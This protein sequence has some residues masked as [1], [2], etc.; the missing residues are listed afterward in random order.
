M[1]IINCDQDNI[2]LLT[3]LFVEICEFMKIFDP[4]FRQHLIGERR[5][6][7][8]CRLDVC[9][10]MTILIAF[11]MIGGQNFKQYYKDTILQFH[12]KEFPDPVSYQIFVEIA[13][14][15]VIPLSVFL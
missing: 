2:T 9:K 1:K 6:R 8:F 14:I 13:P 4:V 10:I 11:Q 3:E 7:P 12:R 15:A 5:Q